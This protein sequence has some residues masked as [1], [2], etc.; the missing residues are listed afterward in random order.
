LG[1]SIMCGIS[2]V[3]FT[4]IFVLRYFVDRDAEKRKAALGEAVD[5]SVEPGQSE[6]QEKATD[7]R[8]REAS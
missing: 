1:F 3:Q 8:A 4:M 2:V 6:A 7:V 5:V